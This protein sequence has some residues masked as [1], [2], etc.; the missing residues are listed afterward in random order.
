ML[1]KEVIK[2]L[3]ADFP[4]KSVQVKKGFK[5]KKTGEFKILTGYKPQYITERMNDVFGHENWDFEILQ[6]GT[7]EKIEWVW[8]LGKLT[9]YVSKKDENSVQGPLVRSVMTTKN[10]F[11]TS[12]NGG[13]GLGDAYKGA[14][15]NSF[16]KCSSF[17]DIAHIAYK[18]DLPAPGEAPIDDKIEEAKEELKKECKK[19]DVGKEAFKTLLKTVLKEDREPNSLTTE[20]IKKLTEHLKKNKAPF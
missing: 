2:Q 19:Y 3:R 14:A 11:G 17:L 5:D 4:K 13:A 8:V 18:G 12:Y 6:F 15:T 1:D 9:I 7:D 20:E 16:E 10:Q